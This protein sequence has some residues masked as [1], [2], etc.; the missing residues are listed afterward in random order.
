MY[1]IMIVEDDSVIASEVVKQ[2]ESWGFSAFAAAYLSRVTD[3]FTKQQR[4]PIH[5]TTL[6]RIPGLCF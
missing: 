6:L 5:F 1:K 4:P 2:L 3:E